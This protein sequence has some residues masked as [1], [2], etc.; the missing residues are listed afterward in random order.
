MSILNYFFIGTAF[1]FIM[2]LVLSI[3]DVK[4][5][6]TMKDQNWGLQQRILCV[7]IWPLSALIF[8]VALIK[9]IFWR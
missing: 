4:N 7:L 2:D 8:T 3:K 5:H 9:S 6:P 1:T